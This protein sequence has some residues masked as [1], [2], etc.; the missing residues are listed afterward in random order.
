MEE[1]YE[2]RGKIGQGGLGAVYRGYD[3][4]MSREVAI[5]RISATT[6][7]A[8]LQEESTRQLIKEAGALASLQHPHIVTIYD[9]G[10]DEDGPYVVMEL[11]SGKTLDELIE[12]AP[13][14][15]PDFRELALQTQEALIAAQE[16]DLIHSDLKPSNLMLTWLPSGKFQVKI[17]DFG[18]ATLTHTQSKE[19]IE[20][21]EAVFGSIF[22]MAPE[23]FE[24][25]PLDART[26]IY[27]MGCVYYQA[28]AGVYPFDG[29]TGAEV[30]NSHLQHNVKPLQEVRAD[31]P[32]WVCDWIMWQ[33]NRQ[34]ADRPASSREALQVFLQNDKVPNPKMSLGTPPR[35]QS[36]PQ[37]TSGVAG[38]AGPQTIRIPRPSSPAARVQLGQQ[39]VQPVQQTIE[40]PI[41]SVAPPTSLLAE[42]ESTKTKTAPQPLTPPE[43]S[44]P[45][46]HTAPQPLPDAN[47]PLT[48][49]V[50]L[51]SAQTAPAHTG[52]IYVAATTTIPAE[53]FQHK[54]HGMSKGQKTT[55]AVVLGAVA[56]AA[57]ILIMLLGRKDPSKVIY[58]ELVATAGQNESAEVPVDRAKLDI[59]LK[60]ATA[61]ATSLDPLL[62][63]ALAK[64]KARDSTDVDAVITEFTLKRP[65][66]TPDVRENL[67]REV[68]ARRKDTA[69]VQPLI[70]FAKS[71][72]QPALATA[73]IQATRYSATEDHFPKLL[74]FIQTTANDA[75][76]TAAEETLAKVIEKSS[77]RSV[78][79][80][81]LAPAYING[82]NMKVRASL[83]RLLAAC[84]G[85]QA[86]M[87]VKSALNSPERDS[88]SAA[89]SA[90]A[91]W[92]DESAYPVLLDL[93]SSTQDSNLRTEA[94]DAA[95][96]FVAEIGRNRKPDV[97]EALW[98]KLAPVAKTPAQQKKLITGLKEYGT[99]T[100]AYQ[101]ISAI[102]KD[103]G[104]DATVI[105]LAEQTLNQLRAKN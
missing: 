86:T 56:V 45:S 58:D 73:A 66:L 71:T 87:L 103:A 15:W 1:R 4:R 20:E 94:F 34:A 95:Y 3:T 68:L 6:D 98:T 55:I 10:S 36:M 2:I 59:L 50:P 100:W 82:P 62:Y 43:G 57:G 23:Q 104:N 76:R 48:Q 38:A 11:I 32:V 13:L 99:E 60:A 64:A 101:L 28:L 30:M 89:V 9:V 22:F 81:Q 105:Q 92:G 61:D 102:A 70:D 35:S 74:D 12:R 46:V 29:T 41:P 37:R 83:L 85:E 54:K 77:H 84:G 65:D 88:K 7:D 26:D 63:K 72:D 44:K 5:K 39:P 33:I 14:T 90:L 47:P 91:V 53:F 18:L 49:V 80:G 25:V 24:R 69:A 16:L 40:I 93:L 31:I 42:A 19:E 79:V 51:A 96:H 21:L 67:I 78:F 75:T 52:P 97:T 27:A 8:E 17:V